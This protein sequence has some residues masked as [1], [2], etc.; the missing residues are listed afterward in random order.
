MSHNPHTPS[1]PGRS[2]CACL[3]LLGD[4]GPVTDSLDL[5]PLSVRGAG[6]PCR[7][8]RKAHQVE[9]GDGA[10]ATCQTLRTCRR[11]T[12]ATWRGPHERKLTAAGSSGF[13]VSHSLR[14]RSYQTHGSHNFITSRGCPFSTVSRLREPV[15][16]PGSEVSSQSL[17]W[18]HVVA[19]ASH[20]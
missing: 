13:P 16:L 1:F 2:Q 14:S 17:I 19:G 11:K 3:L 5:L 12:A 8:W 9:D 15:I 7:G 4:L 10:W 20:H 6:Y 18:G